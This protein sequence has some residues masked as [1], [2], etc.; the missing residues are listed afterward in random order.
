MSRLPRVRAAVPALFALATA[1]LAARLVTPP[2]TAIRPLPVE[3]EAYFTPEQIERGKRFV[4]PQV[5]LGLARSAV[6]L[7][8]LAAIARSRRRRLAPNP[9]LDGALRAASITGVLT[10]VQLPLGALSRRRA[11]AA[12]LVT[13]PWRGWA[14]D[15]AKSTAIETTLAAVGGGAVVALT[16]RYPERWWIPAA[17]GAFGVGTLFGALAPVVLAPLFNDFTPLPEGETRADVLELAAAAGVDV[18]EVFS[19][20]ASRRSTVTN[21]YV[22]GLGPTKRVVLYDT[23][24]SNYSR[25]EVRVVVAHELAHVRNRDILRGVVY[26][27]LVAPAAAFGVQQ[28]SWALSSERGTAEALPALALAATLVVGPTGLIVNRVSRAIE[29]R[30]DEFALELSEAPDAFVSFEQ[31]IAVRDLADVEP[32]WVVRRVLATH[33]TTVERIGAALA[34]SKR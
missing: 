34:Y 13:Q 15:V 17:A 24:L 8:A 31:R 4:R 11:M 19:M 26:G 7:G 16:R 2:R 28:L 21:A 20:D 27:G 5:A 3:A 25:E 6:E 30:A 10:V 1:E 9:L 22:T 32:P 12:R 14:A 33:P 29:R 23:L 18:G